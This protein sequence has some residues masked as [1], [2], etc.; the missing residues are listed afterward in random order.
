MAIPWYTGEY[1]P[2]NSVFAV[3]MEQRNLLG[4]TQ[5]HFAFREVLSVAGLEQSVVIPC[6]SL[7]IGYRD[8]SG[9]EIGAGPHVSA[10]RV[11]VVVAVGWTFKLKGLYVPLDAS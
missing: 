1:F 11:G 6:F 7:L 4:D 5:S 2:V 10:S 8:S 3:A 9:F